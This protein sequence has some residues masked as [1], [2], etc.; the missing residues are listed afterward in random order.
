MDW[1]LEVNSQTIHY[2]WGTRTPKTSSLSYNPFIRLN[3]STCSINKVKVRKFRHGKLVIFVSYTFIWNKT[4]DRNVVLIN[5]CLWHCYE[6]VLWVVDEDCCSLIIVHV[7]GL[8]KAWWRLCT[9]RWGLL[10]AVSASLR[11]SSPPSTP[12]WWAP[13]L[14]KDQETGN[15]LN[16]S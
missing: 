9:K 16:R 6:L 15:C 1:R 5:K 12:S 14:S 3:L 2:G 11:S 10:T 8:L 4:V 7:C 13:D